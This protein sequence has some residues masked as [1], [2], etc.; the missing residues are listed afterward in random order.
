M[1][2]LR[3]LFFS[4]VFVGT[5]FFSTV[6]AG[7]E[8][9]PK[10]FSF[11][12]D[13]S[14]YQNGRIPAPTWST[15]GAWEIKNGSLRCTDQLR[16]FA[17][18]ADAA[19]GSKI[20]MEADV[21]PQSPTSPNWKTCGI[22]IMIDTKN[23]WFLSLTEFP[24]KDNSKHIIEFNEML[25]G[26]WQAN[27]NGDTALPELGP[28]KNSSWST[29]TKYRMRIEIDNECARATITKD[30]EFIFQQGFRFEAGKKAVTKGTPA[31]M[32]ASW[33]CLYDNISASVGNTIPVPETAIHKRIPIPKSAI[34]P[35]EFE[36]KDYFTQYENEHLPP[37]PWKFSSFFWEIKEG[38]LH[39][40]D[41][42]K[43]FANIAN[44]PNASTVLVEADVTV[45]SAVGGSWKS[46]GVA[47][48]ADRSN[49][50]LLCLTELPTEGKNP[51]KH[52]IELS[53][54]LE[55]KW[56]A[57]SN[58]DNSLAELGTPKGGTW[59]SGTPYKLRLEMTSEGILGTIFGSTGEVI[60]QKGY[61]FD[62]AKKAVKTGTAVFWN[63]GFDCY[64]DN[65]QI[66]MKDISKQPVFNSK[67]APR[68]QPDVNAPA[69]NTPPMSD[70]KF[71]ASGF[72]RVTEKDGVNWF[73]DPNGYAYFSVGVEQVKYNGHFS[74][75]LGYSPYQK[76]VQELY[77]SPENWAKETSKKMKQF[78][79]NTASI[80]KNRPG[81]TYID[82]VAYT[83]IAQMG[84]GF[85]GFSDLSPITI[86]GFPNV[87]HP[88]WQ[89][90]C[91]YRAEEFCG[92][93]KNDPWL[94]GYYIDNE[95]DWH[96]SNCAAFFIHTTTGKP[97]EYGLILDI[98][99]KPDNHS[100]KQAFFKFLTDKYKDIAGINKAWGTN[101]KGFDDVTSANV[102]INGDPIPLAK[103]DAHEFLRIIAEKYYSVSAAAIRKAD[104]NH[105]ILGTRFAGW[106]QDPVWEMCGKYCDVVSVNHYGFADLENGTAKETREMLNHVVT[107]CKKPIILSEWSFVSLD[108]GMPCQHGAG[109]RFD[110]E[111]QRAEAFRIYQSLIFEQPFIV[112]SDYFMWIDQPSGGMASASNPEDCSYGI[113]NEKDV[114]YP[115]VSAMATKINS[116]AVP[117]H[118]QDVPKLKLD[119]AKG[120]I[121]VENVS[122]EARECTVEIIEDGV[123]REVKVNLADAKPVEIPVLEGVNEG[124]HFVM[125]RAYIPGLVSTDRQS[126]YTSGTVWKSKAP[127]DT[128]V[129]YVS[130]P[131]GKPIENYVAK[132]DLEKV[133]PEGKAVPCAA[134]LYADGSEIPQQLE[135]GD[136][137]KLQLI[138]L[139]DK[140]E[141]R[142]AKFF[143][144]DAAPD[145]KLVEWEDVQVP[146]TLQN[147]RIEI[148]KKADTAILLDE[149]SL[150]GIKLGKMEALIHE[151]LPQDTW[152]P[153]NKLVSLKGKLGPVMVTFEYV[154]ELDNGKKIAAITEVDANGKMKEPQST[155]QGAF[156]T[157]YRVCLTEGVPFYT[158]Q[159]RSIS[160]ISA[161]PW[162]FEHYFH[163]MPSFIGGD[164][165]DDLPNNGQV[166]TEYYEPT[167]L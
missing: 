107:L 35:G 76:N 66:A 15:T 37:T 104:P 108:S 69:Y 125:A 114:P 18:I 16:A 52:L 78:G 162:R 121:V 70:M 155:Q 144:I 33:D 126:Q 161:S 71:D 6:F 109:E 83:L 100:A 139:V 151:K 115:L 56:Q 159:F 129:I 102:F 95:L 51:P 62:E 166:V 123:N 30:N 7:D 1:N 75:K 74:P 21:T 12:D 128:S 138:F 141:P 105:L 11:K 26:K 132:L 80:M 3:S 148:K 164:Q 101:F 67:D 28:L 64:Y 140:L 54:M 92:N 96:G 167:I 34:L 84:S 39:S 4:T 99:N 153:A 14:N 81:Q 137:G 158:V 89:E 120:C 154:L 91:E 82:G 8:I 94:L 98:L 13:F 131:T 19:Y 61:K 43:V 117:L 135:K 59:S 5:L 145:R 133:F 58:G 113:V 77:G 149:V 85:V 106:S 87:F 25:D 27:R 2:C 73:V 116:L 147:G 38:Q 122:S 46:S 103:G 156:Q 152:L 157:K 68:K 93:L 112:G 146:L 150:D 119:T 45:N 134:K 118:R 10:N 160:N 29:G 20:V 32:N 17:T 24:N 163:H 142:S 60:Y 36:Y 130:N 136:D 90:Y 40:A 57:N 97:L 47:I 165:Q 63:N 42:D 65:V 72:F 22:A 9:L 127:E 88:R 49:Y 111:E 31:L 48:M 44:A 79:F 41:R 143:R 124:P 86:N 110:T 23:Y 55:N 53:E 50:W